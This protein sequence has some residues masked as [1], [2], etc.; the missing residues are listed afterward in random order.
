MYIKISNDCY[1]IFSNNQWKS[2][3]KEYYESLIEN[4]YE[5]LYSDTDCDIIMI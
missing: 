4:G 2:I 5:T 3:T 1:F